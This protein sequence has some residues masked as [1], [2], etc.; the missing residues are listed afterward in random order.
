MRKLNNNTDKDYNYR[1]SSKNYS[2][3][4]EDMGILLHTQI[5]HEYKR[6]SKTLK[7]FT[8]CFEVQT[9]IQDHYNLVHLTHI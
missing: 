8:V 3:S 7:Y 6:R 4:N 5:L 2:V 9:R 1:V